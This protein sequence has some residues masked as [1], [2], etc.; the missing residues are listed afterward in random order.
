MKVA[1]HVASAL[2]GGACLQGPANLAPVASR[3]AALTAAAGLAAVALPASPAFADGIIPTYG[4]IDKSAGMDDAWTLHEGPFDDAFFKD[5]QV[6]KAAPDFVYKFIKPGEGD[7]KPVPNQKVFVNYRGYLMDG[8][9][10]DSSFGKGEAFGFRLNRGK[11]IRGWEGIVPG[12]TVGQRVVVKIPPEYAYGDKKVG[13]I[14][15]N[16]PLIFCACTA[17]SNHRHVRSRAR[18]FSV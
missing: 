18:C 2:L 11:V 7:T 15:P 13:K 3:R 9:L 6:S 12:M 14:P 5:F 10:V 17:I 1:A 8:T 16:S 4:M